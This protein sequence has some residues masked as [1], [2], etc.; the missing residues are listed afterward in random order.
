[1]HP[2]TL[3]RGVA[4]GPNSLNSNNTQGSTHS[5]S[6][7]DTQGRVGQPTLSDSTTPSDLWYYSG[8]DDKGTPQLASTSSSSMI[9]PTSTFYN[10]EDNSVPHTDQQYQ[11]WLASYNGH[12]QQQ[13]AQF[14]S[15]YQRDAPPT[16]ATQQNPYNYLQ[17]SYAS[18][19]SLSHYAGSTAGTVTQANAGGLDPVGH[20]YQTGDMYPAYYPDLLSAANSSSA[21]SPEHGNAY[22]TSTSHSYTNSPDSVYQEQAKHQQVFTQQQQQ[23]QQPRQAH[24]KSN[25]PAQSS[26]FLQP[27]AR[28]LPQRNTS[29]EHGSQA[30]HSNPP[31]LHSSSL[32]PPPNSWSNKPVYSNKSQAQQPQFKV[33][34]T[35]STS[36]AGPSQTNPVTITGQ[37]KRTAGVPTVQASPP[38]A[39]GSAAAQAGAKRKRVKKSET[40]EWS[41]YGGEVASDSDS[42]YDDDGSGLGMTGG[43]GIGLGGLGVVGKGGKRERRS[44]L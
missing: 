44:R 19:N 30:P 4:G 28:Y 18:S 20:T 24:T 10:A 15:P 9:G 13:Q 5:R 29:S 32:S 40:V 12:P 21:S 3:G 33:T 2:S 14:T 23:H 25:L 35:A 1:M 43:I 26:Q 36:N 6:S 27:P 31:S 8:S 39:N 42:D 37:V 38:R 7:T 11:Q 41:S 34:S 22:P 17:G 16:G